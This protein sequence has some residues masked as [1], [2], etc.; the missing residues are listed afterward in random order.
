V[1][2]R[3]RKCT[4]ILAL[5]VPSNISVDVTTTSWCLYDSESRKYIGFREDSK[6]EVASLTKIMTVLVSIEALEK[7]SVG[8]NI[9]FSVVLKVRITETAA[10]LIGTSAYLKQG[11]WIDI[12]DLLYG[13]MLP[14]G[15]D[16]A[17][18]LAEYIGY[19]LSKKPEDAFRADLRDGKIDLSQ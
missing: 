4:K 14:S 10:N 7:F 9:Y 6:R 8:C 19:F 2:G 1:G 17:Y 16:A 13:A 15:N 18:S 11:N 3:I 12:K 5:L